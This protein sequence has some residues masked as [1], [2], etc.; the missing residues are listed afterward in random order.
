MA[1]SVLNQ[2]S[3]LFWNYLMGYGVGFL[4]AFGLAWLIN[5]SS[6]LSS[7][8]LAGGAIWGVVIGTGMGTALNLLYWAM[9]VNWGK[10]SMAR[11]P[12]FMA[13]VNIALFLMALVF[14]TLTHVS[15]LDSV[16]V[17]ATAILVGVAVGLLY[18]AIYLPVEMAGTFRKLDT[19]D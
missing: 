7:D 9:L 17:P 16:M 3:D 15:F 6:S 8:L 18:M 11:T 10:T 12:A 14:P 5:T 4:I 2:M 19:S 1:N 13:S